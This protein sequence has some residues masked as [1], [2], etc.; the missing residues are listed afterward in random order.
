MESSV[1]AESRGTEEARGGEIEI[2]GT[3]EWEFQGNKGRRW[4]GAGHSP[5]GAAGAMP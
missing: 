2:G 4:R 1:T 3:R 5:R